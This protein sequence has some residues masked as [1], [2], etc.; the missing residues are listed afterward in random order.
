MLDFVVRRL[1]FS[2]E[3]QSIHSY[4]LTQLAVVFLVAA[5]LAFCAFLFA[6]NVSNDPSSRELGDMNALATWSG[7][8]SLFSATIAVLCWTLRMKV[9]KDEGRKTEAIPATDSSRA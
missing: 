5:A 8:L 9:K 6:Q 1:V 2:H 7:Y 4:V 3:K